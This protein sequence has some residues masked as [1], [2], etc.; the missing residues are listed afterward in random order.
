MSE[1]KEPKFFCTDLHKESDDFYKKEKFF[2][3]RTTED[4][5]NLFQKIQE[6][7]IAGESTALY[8]YSKEAL[9]NIYQFNS[10][11]KII[12]ILRDP[13][14]F[15]HSWHAHLF[16][17][18]Q[19]KIKNLNKALKLEKERIMGKNICSNQII[20]PSFLYYSEL[21]TFSKYIKRYL[22]Y[23][24]GGNIKILILDDLKDDPSASYK[25]IL[26]FLGVNNIDFLPIF[27]KKNQ[28][29]KIIFLRELL[30]SSNYKLIKKPLQYTIPKYVRKKL[31]FYLKRKNKRMDRRKLINK[32]LEVNLKKR[33]KPEVKE[34]SKLLNRDL[35][36]LWGYNKIDK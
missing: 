36:N 5:I 13:C 29:G 35:I 22:N 2:S 1:P 30:K 25:E 27:E 6:E 21:A 26:E 7:K 19:E 14:L 8:L 4:Y 32:K 23:F 24:G 16:R 11:S 33:F 31:F 34:L 3:F 28:K 10:R 17:E 15:I 20:C 12:I 9:N 18:S